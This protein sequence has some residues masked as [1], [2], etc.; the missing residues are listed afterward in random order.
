MQLA[1]CSFW[2][3]MEPVTP[4]HGFWV[5]FFFSVNAIVGCGV[6]AV[7]W[8]FQQAGV[9]LSSFLV[10]FAGFLALIFCFQ[11]LEI[12]SRLE[13]YVQRI[14]SKDSI[15]EDTKL[16]AAPQEPTIRERKFDMEEMVGLMYGETAKG[17]FIVALGLQIF[18]TLTAFSTVFAKTLTEF[19]PIFGA[20]CSDPD[21]LDTSC[22]LTYL[23]YLLLYAV[24]MFYLCLRRYED[25][26]LLQ[27]ILACAR[28][29]VLFL[30]ILT[31]LIA[32]LRQETLTN[33]SDRPFSTPRLAHIFP[34]SGV[35]FSIFFLAISYHNT[36]PNISQLIRTKAQTLP[37]MMMVTIGTVTVVFL[38]VGV[39][40][41]LAVDDVNELV[42][43]EWH[44]Y[45]AGHSSPT[46]YTYPI[47]YVILL[48]PAVDVLSIFP[49]YCIS[50]SDNII[51]LVYGYDYEGRIG[52]WEFWFFRA[53]TILP[54]L[55]LAAILYDLVSRM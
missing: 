11:M 28:F 14:E 53:I 38:A 4:R 51:A 31:A 42:T 13:L 30:I 3:I 29:V 35:V 32:I 9:V 34:E 6:L 46:W 17:V 50:L 22:K 49:I 25:Q 36:I 16:L 5:G 40:V 33:D 2:D 54:P 47:A 10:L 48:F 45:S 44:G 43:L 8:S 39:T 20:S 37:M 12:M 1:T 26:V 19:V 27:M 15:D 41:A 18:G 21:H 55:V 24:V 7:P 52:K 23:S